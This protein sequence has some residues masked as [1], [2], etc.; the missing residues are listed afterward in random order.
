MIEHPPGCPRPVMRGAPSAAA[1]LGP[2]AVWQAGQNSSPSATAAEQFGHE[3][4]VTII[5]KPRCPVSPQRPVRPTLG[6]LPRP[7]ELDWSPNTASGRLRDLYQYRAFSESLLSRAPS[8]RLRHA[9]TLCMYSRPTMTGERGRH[10]TGAPCLRRL[11]IAVL[12][13]LGAAFLLAPDAGAVQVTEFTPFAPGAVLRGIASGP[14]GDLWVTDAS[15]DTIVHI[16][17]AS[18]RSANTVCLNLARSRY[19]SSAGRKA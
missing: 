19:R 1:S 14:D 7:P 8:E 6:L 17:P 11:L 9:F 3:T 4:A 5:T 18:E 15:D 13:A 16:N 10:G 2:S 12:A